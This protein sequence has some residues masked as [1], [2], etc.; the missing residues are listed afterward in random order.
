[1]TSSKPCSSQARRTA[2]SVGWT[3]IQRTTFVFVPRSLYERATTMRPSGSI[4]SAERTPPD[5]RRALP[6]GKEESKRK[7]KLRK[8][9]KKAQRRNRG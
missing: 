6:G 7:K 4:S 1:M 9:W 8:L 5:L 2:A 3:G